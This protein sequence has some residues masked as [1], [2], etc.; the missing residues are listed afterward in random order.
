MAPTRRYLRITKYSVLEVRIYSDPPAIADSWLLRRGDPALPRVIE[1]VRPLVLPKLREEIERAKSKSKASKRGVKDT[2]VQDDF[3]M[4]IFLTENS[5]RHSLLTKHK[6]FNEKRRITSNSNRLTGWL[7]S[8]SGD[9]PID[10]DAEDNPSATIAREEEE[11]IVNLDDIPDAGLSTTDT[12]GKRRRVPDEES[13]FV[14]DASEASSV[15]FQTQRTPPS[16]RTR[17]VEDDDNDE[18]GDGALDDKKKMS[19]NT[20]YDGFSIYG[21]ILCLVVKRRGA[22]AAAPSGQKMLESWVS[23]QAAQ[24]AGVVEDDEG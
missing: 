5:M 16:K 6:S 17:T 22:K 2:V 24:D 11:E 14:D 15:G 12:R 1:A 3:E 8:G 7:T 13:L 21:R 4:S 20:S 23:T 19:V 10:V 9:A 18:E